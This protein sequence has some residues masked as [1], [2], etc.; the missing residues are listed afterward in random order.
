MIIFSY[1]NK[2]SPPLIIRQS[3]RTLLMVEPKRLTQRH[4]LL[5]E[6]IY[7]PLIS[8]QL[9]FLFL[10]D[11]KMTEGKLHNFSGIKRTHNRRRLGERTTK[12]HP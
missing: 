1:L 10:F 5:I 11:V 6:L 3:K 12:R 2:N 4:K 9:P 8:N 7:P